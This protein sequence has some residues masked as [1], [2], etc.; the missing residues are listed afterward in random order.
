MALKIVYRNPRRPD[1][2]GMKIVPDELH[3][4]AEKKALEDLGFI[5]TEITTVAGN[6]RSHS[7]RPEDR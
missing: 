1:E 6:G 5:V 4:E 7:P 2:V 3:A